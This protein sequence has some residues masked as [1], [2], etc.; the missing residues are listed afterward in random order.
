[1]IVRVRGVKKVRAKGRVYYYHRKSR[2]RIRAAPGTLAFV[3]EI[4]R[5]D[6]APRPSPERQREPGT[7]GALFAAYRESPE[8]ARLADRTKSDY[9]K[10]F[11]YLSRIDGLP[12]FEIVHLG[13]TKTWQIP[14]ELRNMTVL[15]NL[16]LGAKNNPGEHLLNILVRPTV[17][18]REERAWR[19]RAREILRLTQLDGLADEYAKSL[20][21]GQK[22]LLELARALM[23][24]PAVVLLD[25]PVAGVNLTLAASLM[26]LIER[27]RQAGRTFFLIEHDMNVVM[28][29]CDRVIV[30]HQGRTIADGTPASVKANPAV[31]DSYLGG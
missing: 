29:R 23:T 9:Q 17:V 6:A 4:A 22:K 7:L 1:M 19:T 10:V 31:I 11:D 12:P 20:S 18:R 14:H 28:N 5:L 15:E 13:L 16:M 8:F 25:E 30:M 24:E 2:V 3:R 27:L 21:G 26:D